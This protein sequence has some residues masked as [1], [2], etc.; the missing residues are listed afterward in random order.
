MANYT[1]PLR[2]HGIICA[3]QTAKQ[4]TAHVTPQLK[5]AKPVLL[6]WYNRAGESEYVTE[7]D[8]DADKTSSWLDRFQP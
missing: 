8:W 2:G 7:G 6:L 4:R 1:M 3:V 5:P